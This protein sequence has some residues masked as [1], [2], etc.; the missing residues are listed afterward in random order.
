[1]R[2]PGFVTSKGCG[3]AI[4]GAA[5]PSG[6]HRREPALVPLVGS[7][8]RLELLHSGAV[9]KIDGVA[10]RMSRYPRVATPMGLGSSD[11]TPAVTART[12]TRRSDA[13]PRSRARTG[14]GARTTQAAPSR[15]TTTTSAPSRGTNVVPGDRTTSTVTVSRR[16][17][18]SRTRS[19]PASVRDTTT[20]VPP[21]T[22]HD[23]VDTA[24]TDPTPARPP[25]RRRA[26]PGGGSPGP[27]PW[28]PVPRPG[29]CCDSS[30]RPD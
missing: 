27:L 5:H 29:S 7:A 13:T 16:A 15:T 4:G 21:R 1:M 6:Q 28:R 23:V 9:G 18:S 14:S 12:S 2:A 24:R 30:P 19:R 20:T 17:H 22:C 3:A 11:D 10:R 25:R 8:P 26:E